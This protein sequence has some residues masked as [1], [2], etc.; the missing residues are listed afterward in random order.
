MDEEMRV[1]NKNGKWISIPVP[2]GSLGSVGKSNC[3]GDRVG[4]G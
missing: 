3:C 1:E 2:L 4:S